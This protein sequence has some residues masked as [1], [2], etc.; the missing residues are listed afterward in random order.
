MTFETQERRLVRT[1]LVHWNS[2][3]R[4][5]WYPSV[6]DI[7]PAALAADWDWSFLL[8][9]REPLG[10][11]RFAHIG[12][13]L[14]PDFARDAAPTLEC[15]PVGT[16]L[17]HAVSAVDTA[18]SKRVPVSMGG[19]S[20]LAGQSVRYRSILLPLSDDDRRIDHLLG[21]ANWDLVE[22][23]DGIAPGAHVHERRE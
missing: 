20:E 5:R 1:S 22:T 12:R 18:V 8:E 19:E 14:L 21:V 16:L 4:E 13:R 17:G 9:L 10:L 23:P 3:R 7:D 6:R 11:S 2:L 15:C